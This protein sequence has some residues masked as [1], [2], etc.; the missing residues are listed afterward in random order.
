MLGEPIPEGDEDKIEEVMESIVDEK[1]S[2]IAGMLFELRTFNK[3][4]VN[5]GYFQC[6]IE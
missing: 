3:P 5:G 1:D 4:I 2:L 6:T